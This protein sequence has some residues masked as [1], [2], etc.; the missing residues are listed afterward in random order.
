MQ[1]RNALGREMVADLEA[2]VAKA[3][4]LSL[5]HK[6]RCL[7]LHSVSEAVFCAGT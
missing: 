5:A 2:C 6:V 4:E 7:V 3:T 1:A